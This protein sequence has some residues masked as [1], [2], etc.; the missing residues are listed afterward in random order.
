[1]ANSAKNTETTE[2]PRRGP[3]RP[4]LA[5]TVE[6]ENALL[7]TGTARISFGGKNGVT[8]A[9]ARMRLYNAGKRLD[10]DIKT[11]RHAKGAVRYIQA[12]VQTPEGEQEP[13]QVEAEAEQTEQAEG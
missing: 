3:G 13:E 6:I 2:A 12:D 11:S 7:N 10:L 4:K 9:T 8:E 1:M 5:K